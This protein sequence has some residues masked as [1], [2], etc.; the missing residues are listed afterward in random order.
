MTRPTKLLILISNHQ[1]R[2]TQTDPGF[3]RAISCDF[4]DRSGSHQKKARTIGLLLLVFL[5]IASGVLATGVRHGSTATASRADDLFRRNCARCHGADGR[6]D[7]PLGK[8]YNAPD[9]TDNAWWQ[10]HSEVTGSKRLAGIV[11]RGK[12]GM[13]A[14]AKKLTRAEINLLV[15]YVSKFRKKSR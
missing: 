6:G 2:P 11:S 13:P 5:L 9:F 7:T 12:D 1:R 14:F 4:V 10:K 8:T 3:V 15:G